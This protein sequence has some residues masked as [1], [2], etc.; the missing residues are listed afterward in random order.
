LPGFLFPKARKTGQ[1][2]KPN[3]STRR[4]TLKKTGLVA[5]TAGL[6]TGLA[7]LRHAGNYAA[8]ATHTARRKIKRYFIIDY[9]FLKDQFIMKDLFSHIAH[10]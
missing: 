3:L 6:T 1:F 10:A 9:Q 7:L 5:S 4:G 8:A 2:L